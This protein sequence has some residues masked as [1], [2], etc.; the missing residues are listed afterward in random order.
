MFV[1]SNGQDWSLPAVGVDFMYTTATSILAISPTSGS[2]AGATRVVVTGSNFIKISGE[3]LFGDVPV[4]AT[5]ETSSTIA[6]LSP[7][8]GE[9]S[10]SFEIREDASDSTYSG[11]TFLYT[12]PLSLRDLQPS[13]GPTKGQTRLAITGA[14][15]LSRDLQCK[16]GETIVAGSFVTSSMMHCTTVANPEAVVPV[17]ISNNWADFVGNNN[18]FSFEAP[19]TLSRASVTRGPETG[20]NLITIFGENFK[21]SPSDQIRVQYQFYSYTFHFIEKLQFNDGS[22]IDL[23][24]DLS[25]SGSSISETING[26]FMYN[27]AIDGKE[28]NDA[29]NGGSGDD[30]I[31]GGDGNDNIKAGAGNDSIIGG[32]GADVL[33]GGIGNDQFIFKDL[34]DSTASESD[35]I[36]DFIKGVDRINLSSLGFDSIVEGHGKNSSIHGIDYHFEGGNTIIDD[37]HSS[38]AVKL[39]GEIRLDNNDFVF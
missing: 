24:K 8:N 26:H 23:T 1:S 6:C 2:T 12:A 22:E 18:Y 19:V 7:Q 33:L 11:L 36:L 32:K 39:A 14:N 37:Q 28:G 3:C 25:I 27:T 9:G 17:H 10:V 4:P 35:L 21:N 38:F 5:P 13:Q 29:I 15:F 31:Y 20:Q 34:L 30:K 16:I